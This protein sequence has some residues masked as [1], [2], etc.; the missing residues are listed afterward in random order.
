MSV[1][2]KLLKSLNWMRPVVPV[3]AA[4]L[5]FAAAEAQTTA[6][7]TV[8][9]TFTLNYQVAGTPQPTIT[10]DTDTVIPG[11]IVQGTETR[12]TVDRVIDLT[13][14][15][16]NS[17]LNVAPGAS[18]TGATLIFEVTNTGN[19]AQS[20][21]FSLQDGVDSNGA[22]ANFNATG[23]TITYQI[24]DD[25]TPGFGPGDT[26][27]T[28]PAV[29]PGTATATALQRTPDIAA[30]TVYRVLVSGSIP[31]S[32]A[33]G[34]A[35]DL[36]LIAESRNPVTWAFEGASGSAGNVT[37]A[38]T[39][40]NTQVGVAEN[41]LADGT[42]TAQEIANDG[43]FSR[44][45][46]FL[47][48]SPDLAA[49]KTVAVVATNGRTPFNCASAAPLTGNQFSV[50]GSCVEYLITVVNNGSIATAQ[51]VDVVDVL[52]LQVEFASLAVAGFNASP[53]PVT[54]A[55][56]ASTS[57]DGTASTC[58]VAVENAELAAGAT[59]TLAIRAIVK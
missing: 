55:P 8:E 6:G 18:G 35:D 13:V 7:T 26:A 9:N 5:A 10:N 46:T 20:Y 52:P 42:G 28:V 39:G 50:P 27:V 53:A 45:A 41:V 59:A 29:A 14:A 37:A 25:G 17:P 40:G 54:S 32:Q 30:G 48:A 56:A 57:C 11:A 51:D 31:S 24:D 15:V 34:T 22:A 1:G 21:T 16:T 38:D 12:F 49:S 2:R 43:R 4:G 19:D 33:D 47:V 23:V 58:R 44:Q 36:I 3:L